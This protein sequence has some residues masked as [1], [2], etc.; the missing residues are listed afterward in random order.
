MII[1]QLKKNFFKEGDKSLSPS[2]ALGRGCGAVL[3]RQQTW[4]EGGQDFQVENSFLLIA[5]QLLSCVPL[6]ATPWTTECWASL[7]FTICWSLLKF[8][9]N[10]SVIPSNHLILCHPFLFSVFSSIRV[11]SNGSL[12]QVA[13][14]SERQLLHQSFQ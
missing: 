3:T 14:V 1:L 2:L 8:M 4:E 9:P 11:F 7:S 10:E 5:V 12:H 13:K 6:F